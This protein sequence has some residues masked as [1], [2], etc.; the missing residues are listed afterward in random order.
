MQKQTVKK[1]SIHVTFSLPK[2]VTRLLHS[3]VPK[4]SLSSFVSQAILKALE[5]QAQLK[6]EFLANENDSLMKA[7]MKDWEAIDL[8]VMCTETSAQNLCNKK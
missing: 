1:E 4:C 5:E 8:A 7:E 6:L 2:D 3:L